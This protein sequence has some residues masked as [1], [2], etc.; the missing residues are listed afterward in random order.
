[1]DTNQRQ[2]TSIITP[3]IKAFLNQSTTCPEHLRRFYEKTK[4][5]HD[6]DVVCSDLGISRA[7]YYRYR[8]EVGEGS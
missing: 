8:R 3:A 6:I 5:Q 1:M 2:V 4:A 7:T